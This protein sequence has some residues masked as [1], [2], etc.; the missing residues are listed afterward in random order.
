MPVTHIAEVGVHGEGDK[1]PA[2]GA[3]LLQ[4]VPCAYAKTRAQS[5]FMLTTV[6]LF[7]PAASSTFSAPAVYAN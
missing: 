7:A 1:L 6:Q 5:S 2:I 4:G 3:E